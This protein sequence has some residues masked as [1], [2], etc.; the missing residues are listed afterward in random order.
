MTTLSQVK[1]TDL[2][3]ICLW[4]DETFVGYIENEELFLNPQKSKMLDNLESV[5]LVVIR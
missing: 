4:C 1:V 2:I 5:S 3:I